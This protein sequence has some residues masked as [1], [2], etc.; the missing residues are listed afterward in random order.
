MKTT[1]SKMLTGLLIDPFKQELRRVRVAEGLPT[2]YEVLQCDY[3]DCCCVASDSAQGASLDIWFDDCFLDREPLWPAF[4][5]TGSDSTGGRTHVLHGYALVFAR[6]KE[7]TTISLSS[8][9]QSAEWFARATG[10]QFEHWQLRTD[11]EFIDQ[12]LRTPETELG[13]RFEY[14][15]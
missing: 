8:S 3:V 4:K 11:E 5:V 14:L 2:W 13:G 12:L 6:D 7:G 9:D 15:D 1:K 10:L